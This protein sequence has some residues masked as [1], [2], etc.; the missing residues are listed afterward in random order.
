M[1]KN[2]LV[3]ILIRDHIAPWYIGIVIAHYGNPYEPASI[4]K[5]VVEIEFFFGGSR[6]HGA[7]ITLYSTCN[8]HAGAVPP[9]GNFWRPPP[10]ESPQKFMLVLAFGHPSQLENSGLRNDDAVLLMYYESSVM[11]METC[12]DRIVQVALGC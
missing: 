9:N 5:D 11:E 4:I 10:T 2:W 6:W 12:I 8:I 7:H 1:T 3:G